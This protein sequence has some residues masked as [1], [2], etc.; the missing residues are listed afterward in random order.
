L[1]WLSTIAPK[2]KKLE[3]TL[4]KSLTSLLK[5]RVTIS[6]GRHYEDVDIVSKKIKSLPH[7]YRQAGA[8]GVGKS[9]KGN[10]K[11]GKAEMKTFPYSNI[12]AFQH[13]IS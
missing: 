8:S 9:K 7:A 6:F 3:F 12:P 4:K 5:Y 10:W 13:S 11:S 2:L 1:P